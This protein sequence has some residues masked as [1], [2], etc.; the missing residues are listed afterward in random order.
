MSKFLIPLILFLVL[1]S[2]LAR[3]LFLNPQEI[4]SPLIGKKLPD[5]KLPSLIND[6]YIV[7]SDDLKGGPYLLNVFASWCL[8][9][10]EEH[11]LLLELSESGKLDVYG[12]NYKDQPKNALR[13]LEENGNPY[14]AIGIDADGAY[15]IDLGVYGVPES[16]LVDSEGVIAFKHVGPLNKDVIKNKILKKLKTLP[17]ISE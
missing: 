2:F 12:L 11:P 4:P 5:F 14:K 9:C 10:L 3:G 16:F 1:I 15:S 7:R 8:P 6:S 17:E 13:W